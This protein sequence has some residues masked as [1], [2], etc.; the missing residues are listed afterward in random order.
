MRRRVISY[1]LD[2]SG[3]FLDFR[4]LGL[5]KL[6]LCEPRAQCSDFRG[7]RGELRRKRLFLFQRMFQ[8]E[9]L[10]IEAFQ[11]LRARADAAVFVLIIADGGAL[12][13]KF[14]PLAAGVRRKI[15]AIKLRA[16]PLDLAP[17]FLIRAD[18]FKAFAASMFGLKQAI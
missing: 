2:V 12:R 7:K 18:G 13:G 14:L 1:A 6:P 11:F 5:R 3:D 4:L 9:M 17:T 15:A 16:P 8:P 10:V